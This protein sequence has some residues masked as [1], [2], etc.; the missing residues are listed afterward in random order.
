MVYIYVY[1]N[2]SLNNLKVSIF[3]TSFSNLSQMESLDL[4][5]YKLSEEIPPELVGLTFLVVFNVAH[6]SISERVPNMNAWFAIFN[7]SNKEDNRF[8]CSHH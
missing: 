5:N 1:I 4:F 2:L 8:L 6:N 7:K 3:S